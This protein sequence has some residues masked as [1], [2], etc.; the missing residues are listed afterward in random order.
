VLEM[1]DDDIRPNWIDITPG[2]LRR[3]TNSDIT[4]FL[5]KTGKE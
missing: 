2:L 3:F 1:T 5:L 4:P